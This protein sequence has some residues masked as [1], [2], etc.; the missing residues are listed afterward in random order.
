ML[1]CALRHGWTDDIYGE[2]VQAARAV[3]AELVRALR[4]RDR[5]LQRR[6]D[7][8]G[9]NWADVPAILPE[10]GFLTNP[11]EERLLTSAPYQHRAAVGLCRG[12]L[13]F[14]RRDGARCG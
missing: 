4:A 9:F 10:L 7:I 5:G 11:R 1:H 12:I 13:R 8:T 6:G 2:S 14:L 3:Q